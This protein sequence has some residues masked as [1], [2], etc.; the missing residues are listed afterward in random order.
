MLLLSK[1]KDKHKHKDI[2]ILASGKSVD[3]LP[4]SFLENKIVIGVN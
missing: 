3:F 2:Y 4:T 1:F